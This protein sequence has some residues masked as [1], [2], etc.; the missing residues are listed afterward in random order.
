[1][2]AIPLKRAFLLALVVGV[3]VAVGAW[4][5]SDEA[6]RAAITN[7]VGGKPAQTAA[8]AKPIC[9]RPSTRTSPL[10]SIASRRTW[11]TCPPDPGEAGKATIER[12]LR[13]QLTGTL[14]PC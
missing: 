4:F 13:L 11:R 14:E 10:P 2:R 8:K 9:D 6:T 5:A 12:P 1:M 3:A 7:A